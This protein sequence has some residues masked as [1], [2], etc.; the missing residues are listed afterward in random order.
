MV[1]PSACHEAEPEASLVLAL[2]PGDANLMGV[3]F[4]CVLLRE[5]VKKSALEI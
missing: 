5:D 3:A 2:P 1:R 4:H